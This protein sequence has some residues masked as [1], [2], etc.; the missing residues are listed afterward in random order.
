MVLTRERTSIPGS[1]LKRVFR[2]ILVEDEPRMRAVLRDVINKQSDFHV[3]GEASDGEVG[4][5]LRSLLDGYDFEDLVELQGEPGTAWELTDWIGAGPAKVGSQVAAN[6]DKI[7]TYAF[8]DPGLYFIYLQWDRP[9]L[10][11]LC[12]SFEV[13]AE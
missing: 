3:V 12:D 2:V 6:G 13:V 4:L 5:R 1:G 9:L 7:Q 11:W 10:Y 8:A